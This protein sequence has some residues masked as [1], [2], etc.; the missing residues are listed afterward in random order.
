MAYS[1]INQSR[2][3]IAPYFVVDDVVT[4]ANCPSIPALFR[5]ARNSWL[6]SRSV[7]ASVNCRRIT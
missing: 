5:R 6:Q 4:S 1:V 2:W 7:G 3:S